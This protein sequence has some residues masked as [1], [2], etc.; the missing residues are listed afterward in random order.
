MA[1]AIEIYRAVKSGATSGDGWTVTEPTAHTLSRMRASEE[2][3]ET[4]FTRAYF[5]PRFRLVDAG[6]G[7]H[8]LRAATVASSSPG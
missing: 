2:G 3:G 5:A 8:E 6:E 4:L 7:L 1:T